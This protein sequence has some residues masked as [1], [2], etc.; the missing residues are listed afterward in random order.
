M[1][2]IA[3]I[4]RKIK[5]IHQD[6]ERLKDISHFT[7]DE[8]AKDPMKSAALERVLE[9]IVTRAIDINRHIISEMGSGTEDVKSYYDTFL[10]L[11]LCKVYP[12]Q[13]GELIAPSSGLRNILVHEY[14]EIDPKQLYQSIGDAFKQYG[15]YCDYILKSIEKERG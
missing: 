7:F 3:F 13:F 12:K 1:L 11:S 2:K 5:L 8:V 9:R 10:S 6:L 15:K 14:D 4:K